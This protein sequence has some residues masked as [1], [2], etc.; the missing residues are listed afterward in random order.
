MVQI[1]SAEEPF[2]SPGLYQY[3]LS[4]IK[5][6]DAMGL[7]PRHEVVKSLGLKTMWEVLGHIAKAGICRNFYHD[8]A[9]PSGWDATR[10]QKFLMQLNDAL[11]ES[12][13]PL[14]EW[15]RLIDVFGVDQLARLLRISPSSV[16]RYKENARTTPDDVAARLHFLALL[17][18]DLA[19]AYNDFGVRRWFE[20]TR[21]TLE[22][23]S[24]ASV[25]AREWSPNDPG[26]KKVRDLAQSLVAAPA[27]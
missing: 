13:T 19:G 22:N 3:A 5:R 2:T 20:R 15:P 8:F 27:T 23:R 17:V 7:L 21:T 4:A 1:R 18:G 25:L 24:P 26:P 9:N 12:P 16:R 14:Y 11:E 10:L 6:A